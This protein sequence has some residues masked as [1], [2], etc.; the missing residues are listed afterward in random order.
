MEYGHTAHAAPARAD[1]VADLAH[2]RL[3]HGRVGFV[4][5]VLHRAPVGLVA[6]DPGEDDHAAGTGIVDAGRD[7]IR[8]QRAIDDGVDVLFVHRLVSAEA[9]LRLALL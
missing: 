7:G 2:L 9:P 1:R 6:D 8:R 4:L 3:G 5:E